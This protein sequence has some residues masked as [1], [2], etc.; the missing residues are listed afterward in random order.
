MIANRRTRFSSSGIR[1]HQYPV[2]ARLTRCD[3]YKNLVLS[4]ICHPLGYFARRAHFVRPRVAIV[5]SPVEKDERS[6][7][8]ESFSSFRKASPISSGIENNGSMTDGFGVQ[9]GEA[10][11]LVGG[12][13]IALGA[14]RLYWSIK[15]SF[16]RMLT[17]KTGKELS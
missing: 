14:E 10:L 2:W 5:S 3:S 16:V 7:T 6:N 11:L 12:A 4:E 1:N 13:L 15:P 17:K 9:I 8:M